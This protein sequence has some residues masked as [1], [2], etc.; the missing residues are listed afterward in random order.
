[1]NIKIF[2]FTFVWNNKYILPNFINHYQSQFE[3][4]KI[5]ILDN[6]STDGS[7]KI[8]KKMNCTVLSWKTNNEINNKQLIFMKN[9]VWKSKKKKKNWIIVCDVDELLDINEKQLRKENKQG[10]TI[11]KTKGYEMIGNSKYSNL[12]DIDLTKITKGVESVP[13]SKKILFSAFDIK[14][15]NYNFGSHSCS[16]IGNVVYSKTIYP[17][18]HY[19]WLGI[20]YVVN[21]YIQ[22]NKRRSRYDKDHGYGRHREKNRNQIENIYNDLIKQSV[23]VR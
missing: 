10:T 18:Y 2:I 3:N 21:D 17:L 19:K 13:E 1:M 6:E 9:N 14:E 4:S 12:S 8:A 22:K 5:I 20:E 11:I 15:I 7:D 16:P 23:N